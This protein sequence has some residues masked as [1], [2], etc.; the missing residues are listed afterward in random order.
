VIS[1]ILIIAFSAVLLVYWFRYTCLLIL[2]TRTTRD[3]ASSVVAANDL[4]FHEIQERLRDGVAELDPLQKSLER[5]YRLLSYLLTHT[6]GFEVGGITVEQRMLLLDF[7]LMK[8]WY[9]LTRR[10][11]VPQARAAL[12]EMSQVLGQLA[13]AMGERA[14]SLSRS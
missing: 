10:I 5:D 7:R 12:E 4:S 8:L 3:Y 1:S 11:A 9:G 14:A 13:N 2:K 6:A